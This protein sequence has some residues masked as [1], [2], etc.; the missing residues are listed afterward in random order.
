MDERESGNVVPSAAVA[1]GADIAS[2][3]DLF[4]ANK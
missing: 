1:A 3:A 2:G 4:T